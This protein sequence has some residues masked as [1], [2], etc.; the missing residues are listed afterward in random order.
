MKKST[1]WI[2]ACVMGVSLLT[3]LYLQFSYFE[4]VYRMQKGQFDQAVKRSMGGTARALELNE[5]KVRLAAGASVSD[6]L[7]GS[8]NGHNVLRDSLVR[9]F[10]FVGASLD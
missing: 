5:T 2:I 6:S 8:A 1:I 3:L 4:S 7:G 9:L 10:H